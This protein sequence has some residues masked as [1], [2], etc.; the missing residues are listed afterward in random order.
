MVDENC[1]VRFFVNGSIG[2]K[3]K[4]IVAGGWF[5]PYRDR[6]CKYLKRSINDRQIRMA[7][8]ALARS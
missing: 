8:W 1:K 5:S 2:S 6:I 7:P 3:A 4:K